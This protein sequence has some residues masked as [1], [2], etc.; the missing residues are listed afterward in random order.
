MGNDRNFFEDDVEDRRIRNLWRSGERGEDAQSRRPVWTLAALVA[1]AVIF[2][3]IVW[4]A[5]PRGGVSREALSAPVIRADTGAFRIRPDAPGGMEVADRE[6]TIF[7]AMRGRPGAKAVSDSPVENLLAAEDGPA[8][9]PRDR[10]FAGLNTDPVEGSASPSAS[11]A[12]ESAAGESAAPQSEDLLTIGSPLAPKPPA[13][14]SPAA[15]PSAGTPS[16][17][18]DKVLT[19]SPSAP[20]AAAKT[21]DTATARHSV[22]VEEKRIEKQAEALA[23]AEPAAGAA[24]PVSRTVA[25]ADLERET[26]PAAPPRKAAGVAVRKPAPGSYYVQI[27]SVPTRGG[28][29]KEW[30]VLQA[31]YSALKPLGMRVQEADLGAKGTF[32]RVQ[33]GPMAK[34]DASRICNLIK[35]S[36]PGGCLVVGP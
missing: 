23:K 18:V 19:V 24:A 28:A 10:L 12:G 16:A 26:K 9:V 33:A 6:S 1:A 35:T 32:Y 8:P 21:V 29:S 34:A 31:K 2:S 17:V 22:L 30:T 15:A 25:K 3:A 5:Y 20:L 13:V 14:P 7:D 4:Y 11:A 36:K 27:A